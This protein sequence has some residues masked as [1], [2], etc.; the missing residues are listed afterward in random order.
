[1]EL[2]IAEWLKRCK[3]SIEIN[4]RAELDLSH[5]NEDNHLQVYLTESDLCYKLNNNSEEEIKLK[6]S[7]RALANL[8]ISGRNMSINRR[9]L[10]MVFGDQWKKLILK[11]DIKIRAMK[12][13]EFSLPEQD[14]I[15]IPF[16]YKSNYFQENKAIEC[17]AEQLSDL[18]KWIK[19]RLKENLSTSEIRKE[20]TSMIKYLD[21]LVMSFDDF[22]ES[23]KTK[24][25]LDM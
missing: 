12:L 13:F 14:Y 10:L 11:S 21:D 6:Y 7:D 16:L 23:W 8:L 18:C 4:T 2:F 3:A 19:P 15:L 5:K 22:K 25:K 17:T 9:Y 24:R 1:M 20:Y